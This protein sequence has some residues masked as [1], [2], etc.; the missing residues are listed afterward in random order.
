MALIELNREPSKRDLQVFGLLAAAF[1]GF[2]GSLVLRRTGSLPGASAVWAVAAV[3]TLAYFTLPSLQWPLYTGWMRAV[4]PIGW[5][6]SHLLLA[7]IFYGVLTPLGL[8]RRLFGRD[9]MLRGFDSRRQSYWMK[10]PPVRESSRYF[11][12]S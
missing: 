7:L 11:K 2:V 8:L 6:V 9:P 5:S 10:V 12:Q 1:F 4:Y 3:T